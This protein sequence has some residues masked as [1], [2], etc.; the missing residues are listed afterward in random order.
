[1]PPGTTRDTGS[2]KDAD[3]HLLSRIT[4]AAGLAGLLFTSGC[5]NQII[6][7]S[8]MQRTVAGAIGVA[9]ED[10]TIIDRHSEGLTNTV[11][12]AQTKSGHR[13]ACSINGGGVLTLGMTN[14]TM[15]QPA[16]T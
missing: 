14:G 6:S 4:V 10:V 12:L 8:S 11:I 2:L 3:M 16:G 9:P 7:D 1:M 13:Y 5:A 15:C